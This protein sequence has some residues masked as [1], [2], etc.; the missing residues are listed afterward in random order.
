MLKKLSDSI[1]DWAEEMLALLL[2]EKTLAGAARAELC[3]GLLQF[4]SARHMT[5]MSCS[6]LL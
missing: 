2:F 3:D 1:L 4:D 5:S 6:S